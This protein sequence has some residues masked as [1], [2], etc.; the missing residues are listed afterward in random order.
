MK[1]SK[2]VAISVSIVTASVALAGGGVAIASVTTA[3]PSSLYACVSGPSRTVTGAYTVASNFK[4]CTSGFAVTIG[5]QAVSV[6]RVNAAE[7]IPL[8]T[9][10]AAGE[11]VTQTASCPAGTTLV[12][13]GGTGYADATGSNVAGS[14][15]LTEDGPSVPVT[16]G[17]STSWVAGVW[18]TPP[19]PAP[20]SQT[21]PPPNPGVQAYALC[22]K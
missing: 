2:T 16:G 15:P 14:A 11:L 22:A 7:V 12:G 10:P 18:A 20:G 6:T 19:A 21:T 1:V 9:P 13:G 5:S 8:T 17:A 4:G 3:A